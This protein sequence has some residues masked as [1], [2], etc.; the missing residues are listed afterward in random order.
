MLICD[1]PQGVAPDPQQGHRPGR[2]AGAA[3]RPGQAPDRPARPATSTAT[4]RQGQS[5][6]ARGN[7][8]PDGRL[9][10][11]NGRKPPS[12][13]GHPDHSCFNRA[14]RGHDPPPGQGVRCG[15]ASQEVCRTDSHYGISPTVSM[16]LLYRRVCERVNVRLIQCEFQAET[17]A[18]CGSPEATVR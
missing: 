5:R 16:L 17:R 12:A 18:R 6:T 1:W 15:L 10:H 13:L 3:I 11:G 4:L 8:A 2:S 7:Q 9:R 14:A